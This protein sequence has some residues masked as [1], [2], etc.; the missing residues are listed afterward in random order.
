MKI[1]TVAECLTGTGIKACV[2]GFAGT[3]KTVLMSTLPG[4]GLVISAE[5]G[6]LSLGNVQPEGEMSV[7]EIQSI[8]DLRTAYSML[9]AGGH[10][11]QWTAL[12]SVSEIAEVLLA[13]EKRKTPDPRKAYGVLIDEMGVILRSFRDLP[14][15]VYFV[16]QAEHEKDEQTG[17][18][19]TK[20]L[21]PGSKL[22]AKIPYMF[23]EVFQLV[24]V[25]DR[26]TGAISRWL[27][28]RKDSKCDCK[29]RS[30]KLDAFEPAHLGRVIAKIRGQQVTE[31]A[32]AQPEDVQQNGTT[33]PNANTAAQ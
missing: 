18:I 23:D 16:A 1:K 31:P 11:Y 19:S 14:M 32:P 33:D 13:A 3:G 30:G 29:D 6:L 22:G 28:T 8:E 5:A 21:V 2:F 17:R 25:E 7:V 12:D 15:D 9:K 26:E 20:I 10:H 24:V 4:K 27:Q